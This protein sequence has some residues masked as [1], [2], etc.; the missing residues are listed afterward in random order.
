MPHSQAI[1]L[2]L[3]LWQTYRLVR[4]FR[5]RSLPIRLMSFAYFINYTFGASISYHYTPWLPPL[6]VYAMQVDAASYFPFVLPFMLVLVTF[7]KLISNLLDNLNAESEQF[8]NHTNLIILIA[9]FAGA[10]MKLEP[11]SLRFYFYLAT[12]WGSVQ[13][14]L[15]AGKGRLFYFD[16]WFWLAF[17]WP[18][19]NSLTTGMFYDLILLGVLLIGKLINSQRYQLMKGA[20]LLLIGI[21]GAIIVQKVKPLIRSQQTITWEI[22]K[23]IVQESFDYAEGSTAM[24]AVTVRLNQGYLLSHFLKTHQPD[25]DFYEQGEYLEKLIVSAIF[26]RFL[27]PDKLMSGDRRYFE[28]HTGLRLV[29]NTSMGLGFIAE[30]C[31]DFGPT[32]GLLVFASI[33]IVLFFLFRMARNS[34][35]FLVFFTMSMFYLIRP[36]CDLVTGLGHLIKCFFAFFALSFLTATQRV[37]KGAFEQPSKI[38]LN[39]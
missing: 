21:Q 26:P 16:I 14:I 24:A 30:S 9:F 6:D 31:L 18:L 3:G 33:L 5:L 38:D 4:G 39:Q 37:S 11:A 29:R 7:E 23:S 27:I 20:I 25:E 28:K 10:I 34:G 12:I 19:Y 8:A 17:F 32:W 22:G 1:L 2:L 36:D 15:S 13:Y 35:W